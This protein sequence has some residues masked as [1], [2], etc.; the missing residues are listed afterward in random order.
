MPLFNVGPASLFFGKS[1]SG[2]FKARFEVAE[3][4]GTKG[5]LDNGAEFSIKLDSV[6]SRIGSDTT[7]YVLDPATGEKV[8]GKETRF[9]G[10]TLGVVE[11]ETILGIRNV[12]RN[13]LEAKVEKLSAT[14]VEA[15]VS[16]A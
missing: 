3:N 16:P 2:W 11:A 4:H 5:Q 13:K 12:E 14:T 10:A 1:D 6:T 8:H 15:E 7:D 9:L